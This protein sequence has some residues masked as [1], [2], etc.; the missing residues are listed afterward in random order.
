MLSV[1]A[2]NSQFKNAIITFVVTAIVLLDYEADESEQK[3]K[4]GLQSMKFECFDVPTPPPNS[5]LEMVFGLEIKWPE[6]QQ[7]LDDA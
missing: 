2:P 3:K 1:Y 4:I 6:K 7:Q 5:D